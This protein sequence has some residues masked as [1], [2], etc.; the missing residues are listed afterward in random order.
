M[1]IKYFFC[2]KTLRP[3]VVLLMIWTDACS[4]EKR[5]FSRPNIRMNVQERK[6]PEYSHLLSGSLV[7]KEDLFKKD[8]LIYPT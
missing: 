6:A 3:T 2:A 7:S 8:V 1:L 5:M 4:V